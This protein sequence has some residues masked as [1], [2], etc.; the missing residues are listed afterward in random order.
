MRKG[1]SILGLVQPDLICVLT[2][3]PLNVLILVL[4]L[5]IYNIF[6]IKNM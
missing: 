2:V 4:L 1:K 5:F 3:F 6:M